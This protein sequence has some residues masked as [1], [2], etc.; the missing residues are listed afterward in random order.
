[1]TLSIATLCIE[2]HYAERHFAECRVTF[3]VMLNVLAPYSD[4]F[5]HN[6]KNWAKFYSIFRSH[7]RGG[8]VPEKCFLNLRDWSENYDGKNFS[9]L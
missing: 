9:G 1:M 8:G 3:I 6:L 4:I 7:C 2:C 5:G